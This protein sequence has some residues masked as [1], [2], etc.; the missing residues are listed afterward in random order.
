MVK[1]DLWYTHQPNDSHGDHAAGGVCFHA[2][3]AVSAIKSFSYG[4]LVISWI[5]LRMIIYYVNILILWKRR[6]TA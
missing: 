3:R 4:A 6:L 5:I 2:A 1:P